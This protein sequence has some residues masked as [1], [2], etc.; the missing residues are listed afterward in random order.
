[1]FEYLGS[2][3]TTQQVLIAIAVAIGISNSIPNYVKYWAGIILN[4]RYIQGDIGK[5]I[6]WCWLSLVIYLIITLV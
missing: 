2:L 3:I 4:R 1:M 6:D 5:V